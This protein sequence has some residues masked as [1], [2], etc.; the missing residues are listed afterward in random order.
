MHSAPK[1]PLLTYEEYL[2]QEDQ[3]D[4]RSEFYDGEVFAMAGGTEEHSRIISNVIREV[5][6]GIL[7]QDCSVFEANLKIRIE[8]AN[9]TVYPDAM[10]VC[11]PIDYDQERRDV[12]RNPSI[13]FEV[14]S[15]GTAAYDRGG[16]FHKYQR[17]SSLQEYILIEQKEARIDVF[18]RNAKG[19][20]TFNTYA[21]LESQVRLESLGLEL[22]MKMIYHRVQF[23]K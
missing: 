8:E 6:N 19:I 21:G 3:N 16:K 11:D 20:W 14:L 10:V 5:G 15:K 9:S 4:F 13:V 23:P 22:S 18:H 1:A 12:I 17:L 7:D 2:T